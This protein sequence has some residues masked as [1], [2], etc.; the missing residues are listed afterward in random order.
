MDNEDDILAKHKVSVNVNVAIKHEGVG[1]DFFL[2]EIQDCE[3]MGR[4]S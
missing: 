1:Q 3:N 2:L 4:R